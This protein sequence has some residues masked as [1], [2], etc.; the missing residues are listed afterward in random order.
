MWL[1]VRAALG[2]AVHPGWRQSR[3]WYRRTLEHWGVRPTEQNESL[4]LLP[5]KSL[6]QNAQVSELGVQEGRLSL[7]T[8]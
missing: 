3:S 6:L 2:H 5:L 7:L 1:L 4:A 8:L